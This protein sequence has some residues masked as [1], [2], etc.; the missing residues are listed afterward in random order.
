MTSKTCECGHT[1]AVAWSEPRGAWSCW[2][3]HLAACAG[4]ELDP[5][6]EDTI[7]ALGRY[8]AAC[9]ACRERRRT[10]FSLR[11]SA[12]LCDRCYWQAIDARSAK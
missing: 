12:R 2:R 4:G 5:H 6:V 3:C 1:R 10:E 9:D 8:E 11:V 7:D